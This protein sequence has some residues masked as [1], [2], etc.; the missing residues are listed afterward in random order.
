MASQHPDIAKRWGIKSVPSKLTRAGHF[1]K[2]EHETPVRRAA[3]KRLRGIGLANERKHVTAVN[4]KTPF[5]LPRFE[6]VEPERNKPVPNSRGRS[7]T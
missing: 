3:I 4:K 1:A 2:A 5:N 6:Q 7:L